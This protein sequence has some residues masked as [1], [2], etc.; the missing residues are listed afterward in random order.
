MFEDGEWAKWKEAETGSVG[1]V[2][3]EACM[4]VPIMYNVKAT[5]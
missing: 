5:I 2:G 3:S 1:R 4:G